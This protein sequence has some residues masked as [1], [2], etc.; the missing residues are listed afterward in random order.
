MTDIIAKHDLPFL[1]NAGKLLKLREVFSPIKFGIFYN[2]WAATDG[3]Y[4]AN[5]GWH[6][7]SQSEWN[8]L[9]IYVDS[10]WNYGGHGENEAGGKLKETGTTYWNSPNTGATNE[11]G[12]NGR[13]SGLRDN[14]GT[15]SPLLQEGGYWQS[16]IHSEIYGWGASL[17]YNYA[18]M[19][20][21]T[22][23]PPKKVGLPIRLLKDDSTD[24]GMY[25]GNDGKTYPTIKIGNQV[26]IA[27]NLAETQ[28]RNLD[29]IIFVGEANV[30]ANLTSPAC[31]YD[32]WD[33]VMI[34]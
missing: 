31:C 21:I 23:T 12:F 26:W 20:T 10:N 8:T 5:T 9:G 14:A 11:Y 16:T 2:W 18:S 29:E 1:G 25:I 15:Y 17:L 33:N 27:A 6:L 32:S 24:P 22:Y 3:R 19:S 13:G 30:W 7:P 4:V 34:T 28:Y